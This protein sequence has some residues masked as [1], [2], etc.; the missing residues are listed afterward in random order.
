MQMTGWGG[1]LSSSRVGISLVRN[2]RDR[3]LG[4]IRDR[5]LGNIRDRSLGNAAVF[6]SNRAR[7]RSLLVYSRKGTYRCLN[8]LNSRSFLSAIGLGSRPLVQEESP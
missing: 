4:N 5:S 7:S 2:I 8:F 3:S 1:L 6:R